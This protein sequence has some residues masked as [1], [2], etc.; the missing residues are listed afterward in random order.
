MVV[1]QEGSE[2]LRGGFVGGI[3]LLGQYQSS[4]RSPLRFCRGRE[5]SGGSL[6][7][8]VSQQ[9]AERLKISPVPQNERC[10][11]PPDE[12]E[13]V[14]GASDFDVGGFEEL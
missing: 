1:L 3:R 10:E 9:L 4:D 2:H 14:P 13:L 6:E 7:V 8:A 12:V 5:V 11:R